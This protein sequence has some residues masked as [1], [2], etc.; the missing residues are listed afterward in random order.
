MNQLG[1]SSPNF[2]FTVMNLDPI[3]LKKRWTDGESWPN[4]FVEKVGRFKMPFYACINL[5][6]HEMHLFGLARLKAFPK[7]CA[8]HPLM[9]GV[10][11]WQGVQFHVSTLSD[12]WFYC[13]VLI[14]LQQFCLRLWNRASVRC[15]VFILLSFNAPLA[16][17][18]PKNYK[19]AKY[20]ICKEIR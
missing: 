14:I 3:V 16:K 18:S 2:I 10:D 5:K 17:C 1:E 19:H 11:R 20:W 8:P 15:T 6:G 4:D 12:G 9:L 13:K 7:W